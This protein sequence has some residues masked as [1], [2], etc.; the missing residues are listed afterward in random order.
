[1]SKIVGWIAAR[2]KE[3][4]SWLG[5]ITLVTA[6][7]VKLS[8]EMTEQLITIGGGLAGLVLTLTADPRANLAPTSV[9]AIAAATGVSTSVAAPPP[10]DFKAELN[11]ALETN[12]YMKANSILAEMAQSA[13]KP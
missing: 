12:D 9:A 7:G 5:I 8:P 13:T 10:R 6:A 4:S 2:L 3:R 11:L 1:M